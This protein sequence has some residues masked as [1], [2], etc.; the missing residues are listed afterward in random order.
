ML[1]ESQDE[2]N[3]LDSRMMHSIRQATQDADAILLLVD[4]AAQPQRTLEELQR[5]NA[6][7]IGM[8]CTSKL[9]NRTP[10]I[11]CPNSEARMAT[12]R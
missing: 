5:V 4:A 3:Q 6:E 10:D 9:E 1:A 2:R 11:V 12:C 7:H 8:P